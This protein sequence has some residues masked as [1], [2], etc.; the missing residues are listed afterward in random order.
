[1]LRTDFSDERAW[2]SLRA[3]IEKAGDEFKANVQYISDREY[4]GMEPGELPSLVK[5]SAFA[6]IADHETL[7]MRGRPVLVM[8]LAEQ[9]G[10][11][12]RVLASQ[13]ALVENNLSTA[14]MD[15]EE[16][17]AASDE[18]GIFRGF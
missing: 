11:V 15:F 13:L 8:D 9:P 17:A 7:T 1:M 3:A 6:F 5:D 12:F 10:R 14:N 2:E 18:K 16:F 4:D